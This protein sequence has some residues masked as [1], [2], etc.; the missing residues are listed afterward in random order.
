[1]Q[2]VMAEPIFDNMKK[3]PTESNLSIT[4]NDINIELSKKFL[5]ELRKNIYHG[6]YNEDVVDH[7][8]ENG[9]LVREIEKSPL[10]R[11]LVKEELVKKFFCRFY[12]ESYDGE[13]EI[14]ERKESKYENPLDS[15]TD[16]FFKAYDIRDIKEKN[17]QGQLKRKDDN[18][19]DKQPN[20]KDLVKEKS[21]NIGGEFKNLEILKCWSLETSRRLFNTLSCS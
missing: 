21:M 16:S 12:P 7:I 3:A 18:W 2:E 14:N 5:V 8:A 13:D 1:M 6:T 10:G 15:A 19:N 17:G 20:K 11:R 4:S 9:G